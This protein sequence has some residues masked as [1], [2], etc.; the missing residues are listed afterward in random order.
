MTPLGLALTGYLLLLTVW[1]FRWRENPWWLT[2]P[3]VGGLAA[4][5]LVYGPALWVFVAWGLVTLPYLLNFFGAGDY[6]L[7]LVLF[8]LFPAWPFAVTLGIGT[9]ALAYGMVLWG[10]WR[11]QPPSPEAPAREDLLS[12]GWPGVFVFT[13]PALAYLWLV[14]PLEGMAA[15][16]Q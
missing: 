3:V 1:D 12:K 8:G 4:W 16:G 15:W 2:T 5:R 13:L 9:F 10:T 7:L 14:V 11:R 6:R